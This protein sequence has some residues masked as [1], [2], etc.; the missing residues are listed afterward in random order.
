[1]PLSLLLLHDEHPRLHLSLQPARYTSLTH[2]FTQKVSDLYAL[3]AVVDDDVDGEMCI[4]GLELVSETL[5]DAGDHVLDHALYCPQAGDVFPA[6]VP[7]DQGN[8]ARP[9]LCLRVD[10]AQVHVDVLDGLFQLSPR[11]FDDDD[12]ALDGHSHPSGDQQLLV[13]LDVLHSAGAGVL[14]YQYTPPIYL[15]AN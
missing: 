15:C 1:M 5:C 13:L 2:L 11:S 9:S 14:L 3:S 12:P 7:D 10:Q 4:D 6:S 8:L